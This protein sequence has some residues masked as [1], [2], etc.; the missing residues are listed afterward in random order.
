MD[1]KCCKHSLWLLAVATAA[2]SVFVMRKFKYNTNLAAVCP[3][4]G[5]GGWYFG[6]S[7]TKMFRNA[8]V[9][10]VIYCASVRPSVRNNANTA[11][12]ISAKC[13]DLMGVPKFMA[14]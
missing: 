11:E 7:A 4:R 10:F 6:N 14:I 9:F 2:Q 8:T 13:G 1:C 3:A 5:S 12:L